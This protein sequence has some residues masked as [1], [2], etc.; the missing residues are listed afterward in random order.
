[1][2]AIM[3]LMA[4]RGTVLILQYDFGFLILLADPR[5]AI[6]GYETR[7]LVGTQYRRRK[8]RQKLWYLDVVGLT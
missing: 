8:S 5:S 3:I 2:Q 4:D 7:F 1:M 6:G